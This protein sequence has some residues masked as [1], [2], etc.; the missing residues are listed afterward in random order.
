[1]PPFGFFGELDRRRPAVGGVWPVVV[2]IVLSGRLVRSRRGG[3]IFFSLLL[4]LYA[5]QSSDR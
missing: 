3:E 2:V 5:L 4:L 1:M